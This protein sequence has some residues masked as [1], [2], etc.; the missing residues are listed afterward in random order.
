MLGAYI[1][2]FIPNHLHT[3]EA[4][5]VLNINNCIHETGFSQSQ[6]VHIKHHLL[7]DHLYSHIYKSLA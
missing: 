6:L 1:H 5:H 4:H 3:K 7:L 2:R